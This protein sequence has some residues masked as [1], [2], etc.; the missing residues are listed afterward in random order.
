[1][2]KLKNK[3]NASYVSFEIDEGVFLFANSLGRDQEI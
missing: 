2:F 1:M 3:K